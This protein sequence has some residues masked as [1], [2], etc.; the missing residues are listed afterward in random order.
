MEVAND[1]TTF[2]QIGRMKRANDDEF[3]DFRL[4]G[5]ELGRKNSEEDIPLERVHRQQQRPRSQCFLEMSA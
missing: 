4:E 3:K 1:L 5:Y 2:T